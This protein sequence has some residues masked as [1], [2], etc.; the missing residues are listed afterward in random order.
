MSHSQGFKGHMGQA[1]HRVAKLCPISSF[2]ST[3]FYFSSSS[4]AG[5]RQQAAASGSGISEESREQSEVGCE[6]L[7]VHPQP[8]PA[9]G[10]MGK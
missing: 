4:M 1:N 8:V 6:N 9:V 2:S 5:S 3:G 10:I 7:G